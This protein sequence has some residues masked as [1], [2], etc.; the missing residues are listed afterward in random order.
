MASDT[1][2]M[3]DGHEDFAGSHALIGLG[4][5]ADFAGNHH[6]AECPFGKIIFGGNVRRFYPLEHFI[7]M[8]AENIL[9]RLHRRMLGR[10]TEAA[11]LLAKAIAQW[12]KE[13]SEPD[14]GYFKATPFFL[15]YLENPADVRTRHYD[16]LLGLAYT[17]Q[18]NSPQAQN[19]F[20]RVIQLSTGHLMATLENSLIANGGRTT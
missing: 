11:A 2:G 9:D 18:G 8:F 1:G 7:R 10:E 13:K 20:S 3:K 6:R 19:C 5:E 17:A 16:Y 4:A 12:Q 15:S 14:Y